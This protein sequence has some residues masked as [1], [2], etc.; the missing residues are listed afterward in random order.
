MVHTSTNDLRKSAAEVDKW[1]RSLENWVNASLSTSRNENVEIC[2]KRLVDAF[3]VYPDL[4][5]GA[6]IKR[7]AAKADFKERRH[8]VKKALG[9]SEVDE[10]SQTVILDD[11]IAR[12]VTKQ[13]AEQASRIAAVEEAAKIAAEEKI[14]LAIEEA[15]KKIAVER[16]MRVAAEEAAKSATEG[17]AP[18]V[19][20]RSLRKKMKILSSLPANI[21]LQILM[22]IW[23]L[24]ELKPMSLLLRTM[25]LTLVGVGLM[26]LLLVVMFL[27]LIELRIPKIK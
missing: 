9:E 27:A 2:Y 14:R 1:I 23:A 21:L 4:Y 18:A 13:A 16:A 12:F 26:L 20:A 25:L 24:I 10:H 19:A 6:K 15:A 17:A 11:A 3:K 7:K 5:E 22:R 8:R